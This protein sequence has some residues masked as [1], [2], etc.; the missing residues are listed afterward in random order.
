MFLLIENGEVF[1]P[2]ALGKASVL[3][4]NGKISKMGRL[5]IETLRGL[6]VPLE[7]DIGSGINWGDVAYA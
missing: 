5:S 3:S 6:D 1:T 7:V 4:A 2:D